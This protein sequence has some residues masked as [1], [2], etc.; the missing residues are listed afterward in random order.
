MTI[1]SILVHADAGPG[2]DRRVRLAVRTAAMFDA[3]IVGLGAEALRGIFCSGDP[4]ADAAMIAMAREQVTEDL[5][6]A[7]THFHRLADGVAPAAWI[8]DVGY[9]DAMLSLHARC[10]DLIVASRPTK[11]EGAASAARISDLVLSAGAPVLVCADRDAEFLGDRVVVGWKDTRESRRALADALPFLARAKAVFVVAVSEDPDQADT[12]AALGEVA[13]RLA[14]HGI[15]AVTE[16][17]PKGH[18]MVV[19]ALEDAANRHGADLMV[20][21]A[22]ARSRVQEWLLGGVTEDLSA[23]SSKFVLFSH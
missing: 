1:K 21:G 7:E 17:V 22:F 18:G 13:A 23:A 10:A 14:R 20:V 19:D 8:S 6:A 4:M 5:P 3:A 11:H 2:C 16:T 15:R 9:P 12:A